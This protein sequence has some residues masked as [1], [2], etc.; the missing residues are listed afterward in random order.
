MRLKKSVRNTKFTLAHLSSPP[1]ISQNFSRQRYSDKCPTDRIN[2]MTDAWQTPWGIGTLGIDLTIT[3]CRVDF[4][5]G[6]TWPAR[7]RHFY[8]EIG[9]SL[10]PSV[11]SLL[12]SAELTFIL[13]LHR[14]GQHGADIF[15]RR[16]EAACY[17]LSCFSL[18]SLVVGSFA[19]LPGKRDY[20]EN[21]QPGSPASHT[22]IPAN[23]AGSLVMTSRS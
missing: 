16:L 20:F 7:S 2:K 9:S 18:A 15:I 5:P 13:V 14:L 11:L 12:S 10:Q 8:T 1:N 6:I 21:F 23:R 22:G 19:G 3:N 4:H 17:H